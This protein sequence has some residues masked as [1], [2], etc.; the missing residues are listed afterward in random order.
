MLKL[1]WIIPLGIMLLVAYIIFKEDQ[2]NQKDVYI[3]E[4]G[5]DVDATIIKVSLD[6]NQEGS[7]KVFSIV[8]VKY[9]FDGETIISKRGLRYPLTDK[10]KFEPGQIIKIRVDPIRPF[11]FYYI[12]YENG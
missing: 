2:S 11:I 4:Y 12:D 8:T 5:I 7:N 6:K 9:V 3:R 10:D 1:A